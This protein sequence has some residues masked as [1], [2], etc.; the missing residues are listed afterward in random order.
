MAE[1][2]DI[3]APTGTPPSPIA[4]L[5]QPGQDVAVPPHVHN[6]VDSPLV[7]P[8]S[9]ILP[10]QS[11]VP[12]HNAP[13]GSVVLYAS[14]STFRVYRMHGGTWRTD[15]DTDA[16]AA[17]TLLTSA[18]SIS[19]DTTEGTMYT[20]V[21]AANTLLANQVYKVRIAG[22]L[23]TANG[24]DYVTIR[25]KLN[26]VTIITV[27]TPLG[28]VTDSGFFVE[29]Q[30]TVRT[31]GASGVLQFV[32]H[33]AGASGVIIGH[34]GSS[35]PTTIDTTAAQNFTVTMQWS[36]ALAGNVVRLDQALTEVISL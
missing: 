34:T 28:T 27:T 22:R 35:S 11:T 4:P 18:L 10:V 6:G 5:G 17:D 19:N 7:D 21:T 31:A 26:A 1:E 14:G 30:F 33:G 12:T 23:T 8:H 29:F 13:D 20:R 9:I 15:T 25:L 24:T 2:K 3:I 16:F 32:A 36:N